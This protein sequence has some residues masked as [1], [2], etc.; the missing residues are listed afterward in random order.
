[1]A[2]RI[3]YGYLRIKALSLWE[4]EGIMYVL[5]ICGSP[6]KNSNTEILLREGLKAAEDQGAETQMITIDGT[7]I[8]DCRQCNWCMAKQSEGT[9]CAISD[10]MEALFPKI[11]RADALL[12]ASPVYL[13]RLSGHLAHVLDRMRCLH[14]GKYYA[15]SLKHKVGA[16]IAVSWWRNSGI[17]TTLASIHWAF[18]TYQM[19]IAVPGTGFSLGGAGLSSISGTGSFDPKD[20]HQVLQD[21]YG[22]NTTRKTGESLLELARIIGAGK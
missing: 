13:G 5:G 18:L 14:H 17:E 2:A 6:V 4:Q 12:V 8:E 1:M 19:V 21:G 20:R 15:G 3:R 11:L 10:D 9:Y 7:R 22:L 16:A